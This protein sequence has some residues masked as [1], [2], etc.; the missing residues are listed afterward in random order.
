MMFGVTAFLV[1]SGYLLYYLGNA[2]MVSVVAVLH[3]A[4]G[5]GCPALFLLH[6]FG[7]DPAR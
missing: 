7:R 2:E 6:R 3:W 5:L 4:V 1:V